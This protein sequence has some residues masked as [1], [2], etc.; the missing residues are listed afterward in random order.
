MASLYDLI[1]SPL[2][3]ENNIK[4]LI[5]IYV[6][7]KVDGNTKKI[8]EP[9]ELYRRIIDY[10]KEQITNEKREE[11]YKKFEEYILIPCI[12]RLYKTIQIESPN[13]YIDYDMKH[14]EVDDYFNKNNQ[15]NPLKLYPLTKY[16]K[17]FANFNTYED[18]ADYCSKHN[19]SKI[20]NE[21]A[22]SRIYSKSHQEEVLESFKKKGYTEAEL[23]KANLCAELD[24]KLFNYFNEDPSIMG[25]HVNDNKFDPFFRNH[26]D[27]HSD[28]KLYINASEDTYEVANIFQ[29]ECQNKKINYYYKVVNAAYN[30]YERVDR[31]C[32]FSS[33]KDAK[34]FIEI[35][36]KIKKEHP[37]ITFE[38]PP[39]TVGL[40]DGY[41][42]VGQDSKRTSYNRMIAKII[43]ESISSNFK[44]IPREQIL[45]YT[46]Y[47]PEIINILKEDIVVRAQEQGMDQ[48]LCIYKNSVSELKNIELHNSSPLEKDNNIQLIDM[49]IDTANDKEEVKT[50]TETNS[51]KKY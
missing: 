17:I 36:R 13:I 4:K 7:K 2:K 32:I 45:E 6:A 46:S 29:K 20:G 49:L 8:E 51:N 28:I 19:Y 26:Q 5:E 11:Y 12:S 15:D 37:E 34:Q 14:E 31:M 22:K 23:E 1:E 18:F 30:E 25:F 43:F 21:I 44:N 42:G 41:I 40:I 48:K 10:G 24:R 9:D 39:A 38:K 27:H 3:D 47:N 16:E 35:I 33:I 50:T